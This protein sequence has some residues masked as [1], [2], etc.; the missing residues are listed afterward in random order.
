MVFSLSQMTSKDVAL[1]FERYDDV[2]ILLPVGSL[3]AH[4]PHLPLSTDTMISNAAIERAAERLHKENV[5]GLI[6][7]AVSY[8]VTECALQLSGT[9]SV[10]PETLSMWVKELIAGFLAMGATHVC[11]VN[12]HLEPGQDEAL[13]HALT[14][15]SSHHASLASPLQKRW[16]KQLTSEF[17]Q[18]NCHAGCYETSLILA[19]MPDVVN[20]NIQHTLKPIS[21]SLSDNIDQGVLDFVDMGLLDGYSGDP[22]QAT[23]QEGNESLDI[24]A[25]MIVTTVTEALSHG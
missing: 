24:L 13:V 11:L 12:N 14:D 4:G 19:T 15:F 10:S 5:I 16:A 2:V 18:G 3:E 21:I 7:P 8:G 6:A 25:T 1:V 17:K 9:L 20:T 22:S 23:V